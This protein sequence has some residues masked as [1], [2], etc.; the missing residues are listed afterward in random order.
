MKFATVQEAG[1]KVMP[2]PRNRTNKDSVILK[3]N[4]VAD[5]NIPRHL[6]S[7]TRNKACNALTTLQGA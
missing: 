6:D 2:H 3:L 5:T 4:P 7:H 1:I